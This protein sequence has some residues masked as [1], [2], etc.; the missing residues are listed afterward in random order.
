MLP[1]LPLI[2]FLPV[3]D[4]FLCRLH[5]PLTKTKH[6]LEQQTLSSFFGQIK[7]LLLIPSVH[8]KEYTNS[9]PSHRL[10]S[11]GGGGGRGRWGQSS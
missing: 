10:D 8:T 9:C 3:R 6:Q 1:L 4:P 7:V 5:G 11:W 2:D